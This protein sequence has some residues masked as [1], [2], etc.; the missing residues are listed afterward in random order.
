MP[1]NRDEGSM[2]KSWSRM[3]CTLLLVV[4]GSTAAWAQ[5][6]GQPQ[7]P[8]EKQFREW[9][10]VFNQGDRATLEKFIND[11]YPAGAGRI[12]GEMNFRAGT[13]GFDFRKTVSTTPTQ[14]TAL[15]QE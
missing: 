15:V 2:T 1:T 10:A 3:L 7:S 5:T 8:A 11:N 13:G 4:A 9:L 6:T 14:F 12:D